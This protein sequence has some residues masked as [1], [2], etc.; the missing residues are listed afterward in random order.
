MQF[1]KRLSGVLLLAA[2][3]GCGSV[4]DTPVNVTPPA[5]TDSIKNYLTEVAT[6]GEKGSGLANLEKDIETLKATDSAKAEA[7]KKGYTELQA[8]Q[9]APSIQAK[10]NEMLSKL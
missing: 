8:L 4:R 9:D 7:L 1:G 6:T 2:L 10:A 5:V 3:L